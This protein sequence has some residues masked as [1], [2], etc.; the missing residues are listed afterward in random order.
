MMIPSCRA[1]PF[2]NQ[3]RNASARMNEDGSGTGRCGFL[4]IDHGTGGL[5]TAAPYVITGRSGEVD[6]VSDTIL[7]STFQ[8]PKQ[9]SPFGCSG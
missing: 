2:L 1:H 9:R 6:V 3:E 4:A 7:A 5:P 8:Q